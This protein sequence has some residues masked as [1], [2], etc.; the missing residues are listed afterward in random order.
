MEEPK[1]RIRLVLEQVPEEHQ[2][3]REEFDFQE[4]EKFSSA[5]T[6][7]EIAKAELEK[8]QKTLAEMRS[9]QAGEE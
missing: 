1:Y 2:Y 4:F 8:L 9:Y 3:L 7:F 5:K 6:H